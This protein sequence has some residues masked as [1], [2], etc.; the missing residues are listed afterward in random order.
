MLKFQ[1]SIILKNDVKDIWSKTIDFD[2]WIDWNPNISS[3]KKLV[4]GKVK[5]G[6]QFELDQKGMGKT[7]WT[8]RELKEYEACSWTT[9]YNGI[10]MTAY[11][12]ILKKEDH[13]QN[14]I[15]L[16]IE[17]SGINRFIHR[18][19]SPLYKLA[20]KKENDGFSRSFQ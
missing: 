20:L 11:H 2:N 4:P 19:I 3:S 16:H 8:I 7:T 18:L 14:R 13:V 15:E 17:V 6:D 10:E 5:V 12:Y 1:N 9:V